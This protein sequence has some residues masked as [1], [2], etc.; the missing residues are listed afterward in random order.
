[1]T[2]YA[3]AS[4]F[5][6]GGGGLSDPMSTRGDIIIRDATNTTARLANGAAGTVLSSDG[7]DTSWQAPASNLNQS[8]VLKSGGAISINGGDAAKLD[9]AAGIALFRPGPMDSIPDY[10]ACKNEGRKHYQQP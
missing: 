9:I 5:G 6:G 3:K 10:C 7:T 8:T 4:A 2:Q 1:M